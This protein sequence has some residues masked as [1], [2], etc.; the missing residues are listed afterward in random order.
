MEC[1]TFNLMSKVSE[2]ST[3][4]YSCEIEL[5]SRW[6]EKI[7]QVNGGGGSKYGGRMSRTIT[8]FEMHPRTFDSLLFGL[9]RSGYRFSKFKAEQGKRL[10][11]FK[12]VV[13][14][15]AEDVEYGHVRAKI[16]RRTIKEADGC[17]NLS[18]RQIPIGFT[19]HWH[20]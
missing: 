12:G 3:R 14:Y 7:C 6:S 18:H 15:S 8:R 9:E 16:R 10:G 11:T 20:F 17:G 2:S 1:K 19:S 4:I 5:W 13:I